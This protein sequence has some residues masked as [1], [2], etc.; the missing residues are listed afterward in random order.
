MD[1]LITAHTSKTGHV[2]L[3]RIMTA[4]N[5]LNFVRKVMLSLQPMDETSADLKAMK[6][7]KDITADNSM[8]IENTASQRYISVQEYPGPASKMVSV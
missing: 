5:T 3:Q 1:Y 4:Q 8:V 2:S 6:F 7:M